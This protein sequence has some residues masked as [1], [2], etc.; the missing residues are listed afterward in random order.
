MI[1]VPLILLLALVA[2][3]YLGLA[4]QYLPVLNAIK[5]PLLASFV[6]FVY[7]LRKYGFEELWRQPQA[8]L[9]ILFFALTV[10]ALIHG[11]VRS[12]AIDMAKGQVGYLIL[13]VVSFYLIR[14]KDEIQAFA[15]VFGTVHA[16]LVLTNLQQLTSSSRVAGMRA[17]YFL[18]DGNDFA[19]SLIVAIPLSLMVLSNTRK[20]FPKLI[21]LV[22]TGVLLFGIVGTQS[23]GAT[24]ALLVAAFFYFIYL[25]RSKARAL[26]TGLAMATLLL[27]IA[28]PTYF[29]RV[30]SIGQ[31]EQDSSAQGRLHAWGKAW[32]MAIDH[33]LL[34]VGAG[35][36]NSA[37]GRKYNDGQFFGYASSRWISTHSIYFKTLGEYGFT[38][39]AV[40]IA[41][42]FLNIRYSIQAGTRAKAVDREDDLWRVP[43][44]VGMSVVGFAVA[45]V[46]L[47]G[48]TYPHLFILTAL[49]MRCRV[50][51][52]SASESKLGRANQGNDLKLTPIRQQ[53]Y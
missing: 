21:G 25:A 46:F 52:D 39:V 45:G 23:R 20:V 28:P 1:N 7:V 31:Y 9:A 10:L 50:L 12:Y 38:G 37:Y 53:G 40:L 43:F 33:P 5:L 36:F 19:W 42:I 27:A 15:W 3:E 2:S 17:G 22:V 48:V 11:Y 26:I 30:Q 47:G 32:E 16:F 49:V 51:V 6:L 18:S 44:F 34:G 41:W 4:H 13:M 24:L 29:D 14:T 35:S 8:K